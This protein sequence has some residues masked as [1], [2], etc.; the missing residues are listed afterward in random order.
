MKNDSDCVAAVLRGETRAFEALVQS[1]QHSLYA[2]VRSRVAD[3]AAADDVAQEIFLAAYKN[4]A[5][6]GDPERFAA[7]LFGIARRKVLLY[8]RQKGRRSVE[9]G[10]DFAHVAAPTEP[11]KCEGLLEALLDGLA[12]EQR[13]ILL[14]RFRDGLS[15]REIAKRLDIPLGTVGT[16]LHRARAVASVNYKKWNGAPL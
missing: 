10:A 15:Y 7:W 5:T 11:E 9:T 16:V 13:T 14:L 2:F 12:D 1:Y 6:L 4:L 3:S 8:Y